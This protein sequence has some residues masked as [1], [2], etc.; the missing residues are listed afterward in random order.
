MKIVW[1]CDNK[2][3]TQLFLNKFIVTSNYKYKYRYISLNYFRFWAKFF[4]SK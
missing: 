2:N 4:V 3:K 1:I